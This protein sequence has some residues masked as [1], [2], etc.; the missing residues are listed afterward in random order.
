MKVMSRPGSV[1]SAVNVMNGCSVKVVFIG[2]VAMFSGLIA[3]CPFAPAKEPVP[4]DSVKKL[5][6]LGETSLFQVV[7]VGVKVKIPLI[8]NVPLIGPAAH[9]KSPQDNAPHRSSFVRIILRF[10]LV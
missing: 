3:L 2:S 5:A 7:V 4:P 8:S 10:P 1:G 9:L 6:R